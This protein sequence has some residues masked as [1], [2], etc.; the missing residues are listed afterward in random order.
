MSETSMLDN[1]DQVTE[2]ATHFHVLHD[3]GSTVHLE[4]ER[5]PEMAH[6]IYRSM[7]LGHE[8]A[9][10]AMQN[11]AAQSDGRLH[12]D[13][14]FG[15]GDP[16]PNQTSA[17]QNESTVNDAPANAP[18]DT[19][20][21]VTSA[22]ATPIS[23]PPA[24][25]DAI[26]PQSLQTLDAMR[27]PA[28][29]RPVPV[30]VTAGQPASP[31]ALAAL[32]ALQTGEPVPV[33]KPKP[34]PG[35]TGPVP[36]NDAAESAPPAKDPIDEFYN[37]NDKLI[38]DSYAN[39]QVETDKHLKEVKSINL[40]TD[41]K[42]SL[43]L[44]ETQRQVTDANKLAQEQIDWLR[45]KDNAIDPNRLWHDGRT[46]A[47]IAAGLGLILS[48][49]GSGLQGHGAVNLAS[50][51]IDKALD[52]DVDAQ[53]TARGDRMNLYKLY[54]Q[55]GYDAQNAGR[56]ALADEQS[57]A[58]GLLAREADRT[59][60]VQHRELLQQ[61]S[62]EK[63]QQSFQNRQ[64]SITTHLQLQALPGQIADQHKAA[65][66]QRQLT[67]STL[68]TQ[69]L[70]RRAHEFG[71]A[72]AVRDDARAAGLQKARDH[73]INGGAVTPDVLEQPGFED[74]RK[75]SVT[76]PSGGIAF[77]KTEKDAEEVRGTVE[78]ADKLQSTIKEMRDFAKNVSGSTGTWTE[79]TTKRAHAL[80][81]SA[82]ATVNELAR[83][84]RLSAED[85]KLIES[86]LPDLTNSQT[87]S[88]GDARGEALDQLQATL[89]NS[90]AAAIR[91]HTN[92]PNYGKVTKAE[93]VEQ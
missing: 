71:L 46:G 39:Q 19:P 65:V 66:A 93:R 22:S 57:Y 2:D 21:E 54:L 69:D 41:A 42:R 4:K 26:N 24:A 38:R 47:H 91:A 31:A 12:A 82:V 84:K 18:M 23:S 83:L 14:G 86:Q 58:A 3:D 40:A 1:I 53:K 74:L 73:I 67:A 9:E 85:I 92:K 49:I 50:Q 34:K 80:T 78:A 10:R 52:R 27:A 5:L 36:Q 28:P 32:H 37:K 11:T 87:F 88:F 7:A 33:E 29:A 62:V 44:D 81:D 90:L 16:A 20:V 45:N 15:G 59:A 17:D 79:A 72:K 8:Y 63:Q 30:T 51:V 75:R 76:T 77:A 48:G 55:K 89:N 35:P 13:E 56:L 64:A 70:E 60:N 61:A 25:V 68:K 43:I 6:G